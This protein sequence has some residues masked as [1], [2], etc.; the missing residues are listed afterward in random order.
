MSVVLPAPVGPTMAATE[1]AGIV[2]LT[3]TRVWTL[4]GVRERHVIELD[5]AVKA[6]RAARAGQIAHLDVDGEEGIDPIERDQR[7]RVRVGHLR[8]LADRLVH[9]AQVQQKDDERAGGQPT[10]EDVTRTEP[11]H[12]RTAD[13]DDE[14]DRRRELRLDVAR[15][16]SR[17][18]DALALILEAATLVI[19][20]DRTPSRDGSTKAPPASST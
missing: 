8:Q 18:D 10:I 3:S 1:P 13:G 11:E 7:A 12:G 16:E 20:V 19:L 2:R 15:S 14:L 9:L 17:L 4:W 6:K 5:R